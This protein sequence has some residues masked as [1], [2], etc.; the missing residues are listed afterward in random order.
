MFNKNFG[1][2]KS[3]VIDHSL[4]EAI[5]WEE[6]DNNRYEINE[7]F[8]ANQSK[9]ELQNFDFSKRFEYS[10]VHKNNLRVDIMKNKNR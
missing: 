8:P 9:P 5:Y 7:Y 2:L 3:P 4:C 6:R 10:I 1:E